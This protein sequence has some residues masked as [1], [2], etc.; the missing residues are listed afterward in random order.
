M[1]PLKK[2]AEL[3]PSRDPI[4][5]H[6]EKLLVRRGGDR[7][8]GHAAAVACSNR[9]RP[10]V[11]GARGGQLM[12]EQTSRS[13]RAQEQARRLFATMTGVSGD[14]GNVVARFYWLPA[15]TRVK[16]PDELKPIMRSPSD[17]PKILQWD[18]SGS[19]DEAKLKNDRW[20]GDVT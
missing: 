1:T 3:K 7:H 16:M 12:F 5:R 2:I 20:N 13:R 11:G 8:P 14:A 6:M 18:G 15:N 10:V 19:H 9:E 17:I 4:L